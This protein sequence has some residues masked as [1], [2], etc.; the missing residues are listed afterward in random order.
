MQE[1][2]LLRAAGLGPC[3]NSLSSATEAF[4]AAA[5][6][7]IALP[8]NHLVWVISG[9]F[10][11]DGSPSCTL[12]KQFLADSLERKLRPWWKHPAKWEGGHTPS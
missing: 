10:F 1:R 9:S 5:T 6:S 7:P 12:C 8:M 11:P 3:M 2:L 4:P